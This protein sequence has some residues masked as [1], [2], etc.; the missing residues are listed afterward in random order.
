MDDGGLEI[1]D[2]EISRLFRIRRTILEL[3][4][5]RGYLVLN[6]DQD[7]DQPREEFAS[8]FIAGNGSRE[9]LTMLRQKEDDPSDQ[10][11]VFFPEEAKGK[12]VGV[13][14]I[15]AK[16][17]RME[18]DGINR[19]ILVLQTGLT[20]HAKQ[21][22]ESLSAGEKFRMEVFFENELLVNITRHV[23]VPEHQVLSLKEKQALLRRYKLKESQ[24][25]RI[26]RSDPIA[27]YYGLTHG[28]VVKITRPS[29]TAGKYCSYRFCV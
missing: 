7:M 25:P 28:S 20:P 11:Y 19:A 29:E 23:L 10:I 27:R 4:R 14:P 8:R 16:A 5:D 24:L 2:L 26:Q 22:I 9:T 17:E 21:A 3:L 12:S 1:S 6:N 15:S 13:K 18:T